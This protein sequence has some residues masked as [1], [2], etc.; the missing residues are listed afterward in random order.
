MNPW[1]DGLVAEV[2]LIVAAAGGPLVLM[3]LVAMML[4]VPLRQVL[5]PV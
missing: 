2:P 3:I 5:L 1:L 4:S